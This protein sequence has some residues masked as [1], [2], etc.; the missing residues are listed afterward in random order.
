MEVLAPPE[1]S[2]AIML[3]TT[4]R[5][6]PP[7]NSNTAKANRGV[8]V[9]HGHHGNGNGST[10]DAV[11]CV[12]GVKEFDFNAVF[13]PEQSQAQFYA[14]VAS[15]LVRGLFPN[16]N[17]TEPTRKQNKLVGQSALLFAY[18]ITNAGKTHTIMGDC[19]CNNA[20]NTANN[21]NN[22][23][24]DP[25]VPPNS[26]WGIIPRSLHQIFGQISGM[27]QSMSMNSNPDVR[28]E[29]RL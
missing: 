27:E 15:D 24:D 4:V 20:K 23:H 6:Y 18:G 11:V 3:P 28:Y 10:E 17:E 7:T 19:E 9:V 16:D 29:L 21:N 8:S 5:T 12:K 1:G 13:G 26:K 25:S 2:S 14:G 22:S